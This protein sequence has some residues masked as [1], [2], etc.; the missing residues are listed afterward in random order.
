MLNSIFLPT[1][2][3]EST[4][5]H[6]LPGHTGGAEWCYSLPAH[7]NL[8]HPADKLYKDYQGALENGNNFNI[9]VG[10]DY[11]GRLRDI[12]VKTLKHVGAAIGAGRTPR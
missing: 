9:D 1:N 3:H 12:E 2:S 8:C 6:I 4:N 7:D 11:A 10:P 5:H